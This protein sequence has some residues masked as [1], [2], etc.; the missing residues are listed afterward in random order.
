MEKLVGTAQGAP[1]MRQSNDDDLSDRLNSRY[2]VA[3]LVLFAII[4][5]TNH[6]VGKPMTCWTPVHFKS[7]HTK[8]ATNYCWIKNTYYLPWEAQIPPPGDTA[9]GRKMITY[10]QWIPFILI[11]Q[12]ILF[13]LPSLIWHGLNSRAGIDAD[14]LLSAAHSFA[15]TEMVETRDRTLKM[16]TNQMDRFLMS[17]EDVQSVFCVC[18]AI[19]T[20]CRPFRKR[21]VSEDLCMTSSKWEISRNGTLYSQ[22]YWSIQRAIETLELKHLANYD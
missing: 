20:C 9:S 8:F 22:K 4:V 1:S 14:N 19:G 12:A 16:V 13:Y 2:T 10:Y 6:Y 18:K 21:Q 5:M 7:S 3:I 15:K 17:L 11:G